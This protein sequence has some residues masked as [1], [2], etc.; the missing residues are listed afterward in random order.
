MQD[1]NIRSKTSRNKK[2]QAAKRR[3]LNPEH[4]REIEQCSFRK[5]KAENLQHIRQIN[6][7]SVR[8]R[9]KAT[10][11][12]SVSQITCSSHELQPQEIKYDV[13]S[14]INLFHKNIACGPEY[15]CTCCDQLWYKCSVVKCDPHKYKACSPD[16]VESCLTG[17]K[18]VN[19]TEWICI[20]CNSSL[21]KAGYPAVLKPIKW[22]F[23]ISLMY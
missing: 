9:R 19:D 12:A 18:S 16:I 13:I 11:V 2:H 14:M 7:Q 5:R 23:L 17:F 22:V 8:K 1:S 3:K 15:V 4:V 10:A 6:K 21:K 20:T